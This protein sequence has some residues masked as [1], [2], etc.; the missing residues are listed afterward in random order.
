MDLQR[1]ARQWTS[2]KN[3]RVIDHIRA[4]RRADVASLG[5][6]WAL[7]GRHGSRFKLA[8]ALAGHLLLSIRYGD[9]P[10]RN[11][12][13]TTIVDDADQ[14]ILSTGCCA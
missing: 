3:S 6:C 4:H 10:G 11:V 2:D 5:A 1:H 13:W 12:G 7:I 8:Q 14:V 9:E